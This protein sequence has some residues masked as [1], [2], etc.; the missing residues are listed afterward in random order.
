VAGSTGTI[1]HFPIVGSDIQPE[2]PDFVDVQRVESGIVAISMDEQNNE[3]LIGTEAGCIHYV[4]FQEKIAIRLVSGNN[5]NQDSI[6]FCRF[7]KFNQEIFY[8]SCGPK[9]DECK[10]YTSLNCDQVHCF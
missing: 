2:S 8:T 3:G 5:H 10:I 4:N 1:A 6:N 7:D 9:S